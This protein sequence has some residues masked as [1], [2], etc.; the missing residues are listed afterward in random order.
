M[1]QDCPEFFFFT[2]LFAAQAGASKVIAVE[3]SEKMAAV[4]SQVKSGHI[5]YFFILM[6]IVFYQI[7]F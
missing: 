5:N 3:A 2:S 6:I 4:A 7:L 1:S